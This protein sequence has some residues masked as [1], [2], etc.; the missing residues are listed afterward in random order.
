MRVHTP[1]I[2]S[3]ALLLAAAPAAAQDAM[4]RFAPAEEGPPTLDGHG[5]LTLTGVAKWMTAAGSVAAAGWGLWA[6]ARAD[7]RYRELEARCLADPPL[8]SSRGE[9]GAFTDPALEAEYQDILTLDRHT[10]WALV[11]SQVG[12][13]ASVALF[14]LDMGRE[15]G[16]PS[17]VPFDPSALQVAPARG[18]GVEV[19]VRVGR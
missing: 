15:N 17:I 9:G 19:G 2:L 5:A 16:G 6:H 18:G 4:H 7:D 10:R 11:G 13:L 1:L 14:I 12:V 8:C 3:L